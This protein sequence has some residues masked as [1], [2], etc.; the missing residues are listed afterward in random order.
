MHGIPHLD[1][2]SLAIT[3]PIVITIIMVINTRG[4][5][6]E[7][8]GGG[9]KD[10]A[11]IAI[12]STIPTMTIAHSKIVTTKTRKRA[13]AFTVERLAIGNETVGKK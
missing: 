8:H 6:K 11:E 2:E 9:T 7:I 3:N 10:K 13:N 5:R 12:I 4:I 1:K